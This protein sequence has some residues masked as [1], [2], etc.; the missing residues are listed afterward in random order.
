MNRVSL[1]SSF[2]PLAR[3]FYARPVLEVARAMVGKLLVHATSGGPLVGRIVEVEAYRGPE[4]LASH[5]SKGRRTAR[6]EAMYGEAGRAY[7][8]LLYGSS[9]AFNVVTGE[10][11]QAHAV[12]VR[13]IE[14]VAGLD[15]MSARRGM[16]VT[17]RALCNGPGKLCKA[18]DIDRRF[19][20]VDL[21]A[22]PLFLAEGRRGKLGRSHRINID[23]AGAWIEKPWRFYERGNRWVSVRPRD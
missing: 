8:Y 22:P 1:A 21:C 10:E 6:N 2:T 11:G 15:V 4:D 3:S 19:Y 5:S 20:G 14:P 23:Y 12:L 17:D 9:W 18:M 16:K 7:V 13:A